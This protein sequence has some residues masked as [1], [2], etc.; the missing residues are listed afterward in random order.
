M[1]KKYEWSSSHSFQ[2]EATLLLMEPDDR[3][4]D[5][6]WTQKLDDDILFH[7]CWKQRK[8]IAKYCREELANK[9][10]VGEVGIVVFWR[11]KH[12]SVAVWC[13]PGILKYEYSIRLQ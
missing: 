9:S 12:V 5:A 10:I 2:N 7:V 13:T 1:K 11:R 8:T 3:P 4:Y 6:I